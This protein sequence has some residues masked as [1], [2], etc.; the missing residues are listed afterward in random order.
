MMIETYISLVLI[1]ILFFIYCLL[2]FS[3]FFSPSSIKSILDSAPPVPTPKREIEAALKLLKPQSGTIFHDFGSGT[4]RVLKTAEKR[5]KV[6]GVGFEHSAFFWLISN[7]L[8]RISGLE[9]RAV[10]KSLD[11]ADISGVDQAYC[12]TS[13]KIMSRLEKRIIEEELELKLVSYCFPF[14]GLKPKEIK[15]SPRGRKI[16]L[17]DTT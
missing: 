5:Y 17:Y 7:T 8:L 3:L 11:Q 14:P 16:F 13:Q 10:K 12:Y 6:R 15:R 2:V 1:L 9:S 4:G